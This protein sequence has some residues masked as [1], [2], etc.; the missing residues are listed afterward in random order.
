MKKKI[1]CIIPAR[2]G[3]KGLKNKN[4]LH[5]SGKKLIYYPIK[6]AE[7]L[8]EIDKIVF[9]SDSIRYLNYVKKNFSCEISKRPKKLSSSNSKIYDVIRFILNDQKKRNNLD[10]DIILML[11][12]TSPLTVKKDVR[13]ALLLLKKKYNHLDSVAP[14]VNIDKFDPM[15]S[16]KLKRNLFSNKKMPNKTNRKLNQ[17]FYLSGNFYLSK[18]DSFYKNSGFYSKRTYA[19]KVDRKYYSDIDDIIDFKISEFKKKF[20]KIK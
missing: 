3:S 17:C 8:K 19:L 13:K 7:S 14:V 9:S 10:F 12:P 6:L 20:F 5:F 1:I 18:V 15:F 4:F 2:Q 16:I 11:E